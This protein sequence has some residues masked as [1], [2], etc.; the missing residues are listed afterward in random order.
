MLTH[1]STQLLPGAVP[2]F[3]ITFPPLPMRTNSRKK[4]LR[5]SVLGIDRI[6]QGHQQWAVIKISTYEANA[7]ARTGACR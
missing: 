6:D 4:S 7:L 3:L 5:S 1:F 2:G